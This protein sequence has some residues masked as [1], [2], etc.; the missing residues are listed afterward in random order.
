MK[1]GAVVSPDAEGAKEERIVRGSV[2]RAKE[3]SEE[4]GVVSGGTDMD[5]SM[6][7]AGAVAAALTVASARGEGVSSM[8]AM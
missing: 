5:L 3:K 1:T 6:G 4:E 7:L 8:P 2:P